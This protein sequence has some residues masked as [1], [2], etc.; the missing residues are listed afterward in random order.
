LRDAAL[1]KVGLELNGYIDQHGLPMVAERVVALLAS[2]PCCLLSDR[3]AQV[4][5][6][7]I[8]LLK[9]LLD[10]SSSGGSL[11]PELSSQLE[12][13]AAQLANKLGDGQAR[14]R[15]EATGGLIAI[16]KTRAGA[17]VVAQVMVGKMDKR[18]L[19]PNA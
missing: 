7:S 4:A 18:D 16:G 1:K 8:S 10:I 19:R 5:L 15:T 12:S 9:A 17:Q 13:L 3:I 11:P 14:V 2:Q 6:Q